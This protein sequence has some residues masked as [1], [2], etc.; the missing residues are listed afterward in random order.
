MLM[1]MTMVKMIMMF[2][3]W[4]VGVVRADQANTQT[5]KQ[6]IV[7]MMLTDDDD[8]VDNDIMMTMRMIMILLTLMTMMTVMSMI[9]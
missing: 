8:N 5:L 4:K 6:H 1:M 9:V 7:K 3:Q 2:E